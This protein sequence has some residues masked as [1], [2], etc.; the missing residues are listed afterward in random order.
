MGGQ[1]ERKAERKAKR[2][3]IKLRNSLISPTTLEAVSGRL[4]PGGQLSHGVQPPS[5][6]HR[7]TR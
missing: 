7:G 6:Q 4:N 5:L 1:V 2:S 3:K